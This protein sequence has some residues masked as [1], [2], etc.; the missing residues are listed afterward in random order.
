MEARGSPYM[1][2]PH[3]KNSINN[4]LPIQKII[5]IIIDYRIEQI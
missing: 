1:P 4:R 3:K 2:V 5:I